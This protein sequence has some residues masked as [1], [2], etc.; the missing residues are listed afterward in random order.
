MIIDA[1]NSVMGRLASTAAKELLKGEKVHIIN[2]EKAIITGNRKLMIS[3]YM[4]RRQRGSPQHGPFFPTRPDMIMRRCVRGMLPYKTNKGRNALKNLRVSIGG[5]DPDAKKI[6]Q[7]QIKTSF[8]TVGEIATLLG[9][10][11]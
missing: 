2:S 8:V 6:A 1:T 10:R 5:S 11:K 4:Q 7:K 3:D 9:W